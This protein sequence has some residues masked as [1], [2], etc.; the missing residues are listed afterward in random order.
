MTVTQLPNRNRPS[1]DLLDL[2]DKL[3]R[4]INYARAITLAILAVG[5]AGTDHEQENDTLGQLA[6]D[7][8]ARLK[9]MAAALEHIRSSAAQAASA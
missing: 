1:G 9:A 3:N 5:P 4:E 6:N 7:H 8:W 2:A